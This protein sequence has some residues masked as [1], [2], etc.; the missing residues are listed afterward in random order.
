MTAA[1][2]RPAS[3]D[4]V[5]RAVAIAAK[6]PYA[7]IYAALAHGMG[8]QRATARIGKQARSARHGVSVKRKW[9][10][11]YMGSLGFVWHPAMRIGSGCKVHLRADELPPGRLVVTLSRHYAAVIDGVVHDTY[12]S[13]RNGT[14]CVYGY[15]R[16]VQP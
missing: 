13:S 4:C 14:R 2:R 12:D 11:D 1:G 3:G 8:E 5:D 16:Q 10:K 6:R 15:W 9:F 7:E